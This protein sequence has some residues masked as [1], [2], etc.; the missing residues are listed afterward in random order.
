VVLLELVPASVPQPD[1]FDA[2]NDRR[3]KLSPMINRINNCYG[4]AIGFGL[5]PPDVRA[6]KS[7]AAFV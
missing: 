7:H 6:F 3:R 5:L 2:A 4:R 1:L